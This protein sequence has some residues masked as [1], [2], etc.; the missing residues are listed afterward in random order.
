MAT[1]EDQEHARKL[2]K[3]YRARFKQREIQ[4]ATFGLS[5]DPAVV[6]EIDDLRQSIAHLEEHKPQSD[7]VTEAQNVV[8]SQYDGD[9][10]FLIAD[11]NVRNRRQTRLEEKQND[12]AVTVGAISQKLL[13]VVDDIIHNKI[14]AEYGRLRNYRLQVINTLLLLLLVSYLVFWR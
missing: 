7:I 3:L 12:L 1:S 11:G 5:V 9:I 8:R 14:D 6:T 13:I 4:L 10:E 2:L